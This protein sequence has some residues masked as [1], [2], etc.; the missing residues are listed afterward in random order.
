MKKIWGMSSAVPSE[1]RAASGL[2]VGLAKAEFFE[3]SE[4]S[5]SMIG[6]YLP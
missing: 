5:T 3:L 2:A 6:R 1:C 4:L